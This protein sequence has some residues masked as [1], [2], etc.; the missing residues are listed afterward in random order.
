MKLRQL[1]QECEEQEI[2][3]SFDAIVLRRTL[4]QDGTIM[5]RPTG[6]PTVVGI[7][8]AVMLQLSPTD[9][10]V[11]SLLQE[12]KEKELSAF[13]WTI[14]II[15]R[16]WL[17]HAPLFFGLAQS[18]YNPAFNPKVSMSMLRSS[19]LPLILRLCIAA[20]KTEND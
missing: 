3:S 17:G 5:K 10:D 13:I 6:D 1:F 7:W 2:L 16:A 19:P 8:R 11:P 4:N 20:G 14:E 12:G 9:A 18:D 15:D